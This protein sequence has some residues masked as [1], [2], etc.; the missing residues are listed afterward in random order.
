MKKVIVCWKCKRGG[1]TLYKIGTIDY[2][3]E[4][5]RPEVPPIG[6]QSFIKVP[7]PEEIKTAVQQMKEKEEY[8][9]QENTNS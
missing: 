7:T 9:K 1:V 4:E 5:H 2:G 6:N 3:C 8:G